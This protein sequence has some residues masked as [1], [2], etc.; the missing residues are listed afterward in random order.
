MKGLADIVTYL[1]RSILHI[2]E[3]S[4]Y[5]ILLFF[6]SMRYLR[7]VVRRRHEIARQMFNAGAR[8]FGV[9]TV[10]SLF[11]GMILTLRSPSC[12]GSAPHRSRPSARGHTA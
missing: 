6:R 4:G 11:T 1:G 2:L 12:C 10:V 7:N 3:F 9:I 5:T 8:T